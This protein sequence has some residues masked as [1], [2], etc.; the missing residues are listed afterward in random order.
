MNIIEDKLKE[1]DFFDGGII[2]HGNVDYIRDYE[3]IAYIPGQTIAYE[4]RY[5]FKGCLKVNFEVMVK[6]E[7]FS[8]DEKLLD[9]SRQEEPDYPKAFIWAA[10]AI[11]YPGWKLEENTEGL[12]VLENE[13]KL[14]LYKI[15]IETNAY[16]LSIIFN[17]LEIQILKEI[18]K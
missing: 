15:L 16:N 1:Y 10:G 13:Y 17:D 11:A 14:K 5:L 8:M 12:K 6:P 2:R 9:L 7:H 4:V 18:K 3:V